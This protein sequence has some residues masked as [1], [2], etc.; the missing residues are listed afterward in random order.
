MQTIILLSQNLL[1]FSGLNNETNKANMNLYNAITLKKVVT[2]AEDPDVKGI[3]L[4]LHHLDINEVIAAI[5][6][7]RQ[8]FHGPLI[9]LT[10]TFDSHL[11]KKLLKLNVNS[12]LVAYNPS[13]I[14][15]Q[16][17]SLAWLTAQH[18]ISTRPLR[19]K[20]IHDYFITEKK[21]N[22]DLSSYPAKLNGKKLALTTK[23]FKL[24]EYLFEHE[25]QVLSRDQL[26]KGVWQY[27]ESLNSTRIVDIHISHLRDKIE[28]DPRHPQIL[29]TVR[30]WGYILTLH[31]QEVN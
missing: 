14:L 15:A 25:G 26:L 21:Y 4:D 1:L 5:S 7:I 17:D 8:K 11:A 3:V 28:K 20:G 19:H 31:G 12:V 6:E 2:H 18:D 29:K 13:L 23:E 27:D 30:G 9:C 10:K 16:L 24:L 22:L